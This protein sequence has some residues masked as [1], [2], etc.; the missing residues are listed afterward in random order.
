[1]S[2]HNDSVRVN[3]QGKMTQW[4]CQSEP[5][6]K[7]DTMTVSEWTNKE[8]WH[9]DGVR[10]NQQG[11]LT[12]W[13][14]QSEPTRKAD[15][16]SVSEWT[17][18]ESWHHDSEP[19]RKADTMTVSEWTN[20]ESWHNDSVRMNQHGKLRQWQCQ[21]EPTRKSSLYYFFVLFCLTEPDCPEMIW[22]PCAVDQVLKSGN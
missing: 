17:N 2:W 13:Q 11:K 12:Q 9:N 19:T 5:T 7:A 8:S 1:M 22:R 4:Q 18:K 20:K 6:R 14:C 10:V 21:S 15:T 16:M 3:Q